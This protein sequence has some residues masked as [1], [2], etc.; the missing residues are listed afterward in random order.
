MIGRCEN[1]NTDRYR[2]YGARGI[3]VC[4]RWRESFEAFLADM[5]EPSPKM[6]LDR[7]DNNGNYEPGNCRWASRKTQAQN[8][9]SNIIVSI[10]GRTGCLWEVCEKLGY[11]LKM[12]NL[13][14]AR[15]RRGW[16]QSHWF[17]DAETGRKLAFN[18]AWRASVGLPPLKENS[19]QFK[20]GEC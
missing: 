5:G 19:G 1:P 9:R 17:V 11:D 2:F 18:A 4:T 3:R 15:V 7:I 16:P 12:Y 10:E 14:R 13:V 6:T 8:R 20:P